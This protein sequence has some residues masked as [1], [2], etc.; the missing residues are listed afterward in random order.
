MF[1]T[2]LPLVL[3]LYIMFTNVH[4]YNIIKFNI[5]RNLGSGVLEPM[6]AKQKQK[7]GVLLVSKVIHIRAIKLVWLPHTG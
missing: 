3:D 5:G 1:F 6:F 4:Y 2:F 7:F